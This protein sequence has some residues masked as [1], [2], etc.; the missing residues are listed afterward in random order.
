MTRAESQARTRA[1]LI[2]TATEMFLRDGYVTTSLEKV[3]EAAGFTRGAVYSNFRNK[4][5]LCMVVLDEIRAQRAVEI[6]SM[7]VAPSLDE[8]LAQFESW[9]E[10]VIGDEGWTRLEMEFGAYASRDTDLT[11]HMRE[12]LTGLVDLLDAAVT[13]LADQGAITLPVSAR[14]AAVALLSM[15][16]GLGLFRSIDPSLPIGAITNTIRALA[17]NPSEHPARP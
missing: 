13:G 1:Q 15:G 11:E 12:R 3:A 4:D 17:F 5:E 7:F 2:T 10:R 6:A 8:V 9:A 16:V 14:E